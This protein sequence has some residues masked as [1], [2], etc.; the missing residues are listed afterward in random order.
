MLKIFDKASDDQPFFGADLTG[1]F[2]N[3][4]S[5]Y[6]EEIVIYSIN[7]IQLIMCQLKINICIYFYVLYLSRGTYR[8]S[9]V[10]GLR[11]F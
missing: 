10:K 4:V 11:G 6:C 8:T 2:T 3:I 7:S 5:F 1:S 9:T